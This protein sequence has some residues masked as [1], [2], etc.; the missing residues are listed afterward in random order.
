MDLNALQKARNAISINNVSMVIFC[1][2][3]QCI[4]PG[5]VQNTFRFPNGGVQG[6]FRAGATVARSL[7]AAPSSYQTTT[8]C[9]MPACP[10]FSVQVNVCQRR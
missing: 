8:V 7:L 5:F 6:G 10:A 4:K 1:G 2:F 3:R 9:C